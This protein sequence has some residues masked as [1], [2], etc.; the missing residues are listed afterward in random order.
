MQ[1]SLLRLDAQSGHRTLKYYRDMGELKGIRLG[2]RV[3]YRLDDV[4]AF[5]AQKAEQRL[6]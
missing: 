4:L 5:L 3:R 6:R 1:V 2:R